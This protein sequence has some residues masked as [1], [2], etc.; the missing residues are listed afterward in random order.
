MK[1]YAGVHLVKTETT[2]G[3][4]A[5]YSCTLEAWDTVCGK[6]QSEGVR[7]RQ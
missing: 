6:S 4:P 2:L 5:P 1:R 3:D 7:D